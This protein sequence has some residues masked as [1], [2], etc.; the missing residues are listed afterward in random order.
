[1]RRKRF[2]PLLTAA[3]LVCALAGA[4]A[5]AQAICPVT[6]LTSGLQLPLGITQSNQRNLLVSESGPRGTTN[7]GRVTILG[8]DGARRTLLAGLPSGPNDVGDPSGPAGLF[9]R[10]RTLYVA[11]G[12]GDV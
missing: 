4:Q 11:I 2:T 9:L 12:M 6:E 8:L 3:S 1:M 5:S 10:G 7:T